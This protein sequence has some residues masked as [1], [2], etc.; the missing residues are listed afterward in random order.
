MDPVK[1]AVLG[2]PANY[3]G[4]FIGI[5][6]VLIFIIAYMWWQGRGVSKEK[7]ASKRPAKK[8]PTDEEEVEVDELIEEIHD[9]QKK[10]KGKEAK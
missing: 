6:L 5:V 10:K 7:A 9:K 3:P 1:N 4:V 2:A 8:E